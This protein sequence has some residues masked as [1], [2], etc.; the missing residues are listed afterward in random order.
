VAQE[1]ALRERAE[2]QKQESAEALAKTE[3]LLAASTQALQKAREESRASR[4]W[5]MVESASTAAAEGELED[6]RRCAA[7]SPTLS[8]LHERRRRRLQL[9]TSTNT[10]QFR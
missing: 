1:V 8:R 2:E 7:E 10:T 3:A 6:S 9:S 4:M 5:G